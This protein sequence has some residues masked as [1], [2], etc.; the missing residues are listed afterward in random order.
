MDNGLGEIEQV[1]YTEPKVGFGND[2]TIVVKNR[3]YR[4]AFKNRAMLEGQKSKKYY[5]QKK[6]KNRRKK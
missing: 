2:G 1:S 4:R 3:A 5:T 6:R